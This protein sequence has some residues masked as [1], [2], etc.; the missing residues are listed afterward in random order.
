MAGFFMF[1][2]IIIIIIGRLWT[3]R[4]KLLLHISSKQVYPTWPVELHLVQDRGPL[5]CFELRWHIEESNVHLPQ[6]NKLVLCTSVKHRTL[7]H[8]NSF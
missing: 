6:I 7:F 2:F 3:E 8:L 5:R 1:E 4:W